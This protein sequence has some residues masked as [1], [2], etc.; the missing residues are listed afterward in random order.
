[1]KTKF[2]IFLLG[3]FLSDIALS[4]TYDLTC[5]VRDKVA[6]AYIYSQDDELKIVGEATL[7]IFDDEGDVLEKHVKNV[8]EYMTPRGERIIFDMFTSHSASDCKLTFDDDAI[9]V[10]SFVSESS[11]NI[12][13]HDYYEQKP[14]PIQIGFLWNMSSPRHHHF[15]HRRV[16]IHRNFDRSYFHERN[17]KRITISKPRSGH[18]FSTSF[19]I[20]KKS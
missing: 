20:T 15:D 8:T 4:Q 11:T 14:S 12:V 10:K 18:S 7:V 1:M 17:Y 9:E 13:H 5:S 2:G 3:L 19:Q 16:V 6:R